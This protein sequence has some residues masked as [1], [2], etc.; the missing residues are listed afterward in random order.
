MIPL[1]TQGQTPYDSG[2]PPL[3]IASTSGPL[4]VAAEKPRMKLLKLTEQ[5]QRSSIWPPSGRAV[6]ADAL[7]LLLERPADWEELRQITPDIKVLLAADA[8]E[9]EGVLRQVLPRSCSTCP[10]ARFTKSSRRQLLE[11]VAD[12]ILACPGARRLA[13]QRL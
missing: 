11:S 6:E 4:R 3:V 10:T 9:I 2:T 8:E 1:A 12:D 5:F 7:L 13:L